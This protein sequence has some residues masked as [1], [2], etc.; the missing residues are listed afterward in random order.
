MSGW[1]VVLALHVLGASVWT[2]GHLVLALTVLPRALRSR[3]V[4]VITEFEAGF[5]RIGIPALVVQVATGLWLA[6]RYV[7]PRAW[8]DLGSPLSRVVLAKLALLA[9]TAA[10]AAHARLRVLPGVTSERLGALAA[11]VVPVTVLSVLFVLV[12]LSLRVGGL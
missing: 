11:H 4:E 7:P 8:F 10:L 9:A 1:Y 12:G 5:E 6:A 3:R 2:G